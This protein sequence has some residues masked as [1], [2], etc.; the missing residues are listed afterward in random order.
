MVITSPI[1]LEIGKVYN[2]GDIQGPFEMYGEIYQV[3]RFMVMG[4]A[5][6]EEYWE[7]VNEEYEDPSAVYSREYFYEISMD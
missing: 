7:T 1:K 3:Y 2:E 4:E 5:T 6:E